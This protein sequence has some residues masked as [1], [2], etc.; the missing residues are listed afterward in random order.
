MSKLGR[1]QAAARRR[2]GER[3]AAQRA[4]RRRRPR[5]RTAQRRVNRAPEARRTTRRTAARGDQARRRRR[6]PRAGVRRR[7]AAAA[8]NRARIEPAA[9]GARSHASAL[10]DER[11]ALL[12]SKFGAEPAPHTWEV[13]QE[14]ESG[15]TFLRRGLGTDVLGKL[16]R[17]HWSLQAELDLHGMTVDEAHDALADF[18]VDARSRGLPL[19]PRDPRQGPD[20]AGPRAGAQGQGAQ[21]G[22]RTGTTCSPTAEAPRH[23]GGGGAVVVLLKGAR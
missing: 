11:D 3:G 12:A 13:G 19:R 20:V 17:G 7:R 23:A 15:Q 22:C 5:R 16:R 14:H 10:A 18:L 2:A 8:A 1:P 6:R 9:P 4:G 21:A